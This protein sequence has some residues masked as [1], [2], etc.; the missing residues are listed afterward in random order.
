MIRS[1]LL[2]SL[3]ALVLVSITSIAC[4]VGCGGTCDGDPVA[5]AACDEAKPTCIKA[6]TTQVC[7]DGCSKTYSD[8][9]FASCGFCG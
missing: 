4:F 9:Q 7:K 1:R 8:C 2:P 5:C 3:A 6:C